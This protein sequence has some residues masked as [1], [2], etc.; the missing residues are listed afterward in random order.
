MWWLTPVGAVSW[1]A[2][3]CTVIKSLCSGLNASP[4]NLATDVTADAPLVPARPGRHGGR[5]RYGDPSIGRRRR[6]SAG[7]APSTAN[8]IRRRRRV[9]G[10]APGTDRRARIIDGVRRSP[11]GPGPILNL[12]RAGRR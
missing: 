2:V 4:S 11:A 10:P 5:R 8:D 12:S 3:S 9:S 1:S 6:G 7:A